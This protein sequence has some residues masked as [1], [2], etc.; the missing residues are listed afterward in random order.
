MPWIGEIILFLLPFAAVA[1]WRKWNPDAEP[2]RQFLILAAIGIALAAAG[3]AWYG[4]HRRLDPDM[5][6]E[7]A[8]LRDGDVIR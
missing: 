8:H 1:A 6:Y 5:P 7:P 4:L 2:S 3:A